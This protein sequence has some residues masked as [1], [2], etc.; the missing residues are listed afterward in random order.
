MS[1]ILTTSFLLYL[2]HKPSVLNFPGCSETPLWK[3]GDRGDFKDHRH[4]NILS[5]APCVFLNTSLSENL[6]TLK[7]VSFIY[8]S[9]VLSFVFPFKSP[10]TPLFQRGAYP[11]NFLKKNRILQLKCNLLMGNTIGK[12]PS[13][14]P[15]IYRKREN[16]KI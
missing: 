3:R 9:F 2:T 1:W 5:R 8:S 10:L 14:I 12:F 16:R 13:K 15:Q 4:P 6:R 7:P 11:H